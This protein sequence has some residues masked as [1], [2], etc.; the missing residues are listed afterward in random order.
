MAA[1]RKRSKFGLE[2]M[3]VQVQIDGRCTR[4]HGVGH[5]SHS[6]NWP[7]PTEAKLGSLVDWHPL[8]RGRQIVG[9]RSRHQARVDW[10]QQLVPSC[11]V[12]GMKVQVGP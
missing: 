2:W 3:Q 9:G 5:R 12:L 8:N 4:D 7:Q 11:D 10:C 6:R 1:M